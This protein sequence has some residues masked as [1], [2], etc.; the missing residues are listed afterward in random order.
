M[1]ALLALLACLVAGPESDLD[2]ITQRFDLTRVSEPATGRETLRGPGLTVTFAPGLRIA[3]VNGDVMTLEAPVEISGGKIRLPAS[4]ASLIERLA[5]ARKARPD[6]KPAKP[7][8]RA[9]QLDRPFKIVIDAG[10]GGIH[11]GCTARGGYTEKEVTLDV[12]RRLKELLES[13]GA[14]VVMTRTSD[15]HFSEDIDTDLMHRVRVSDRARPD[16]FL[17]IHC[18]WV[19]N[20]EVRGF[21]IFVSSYPK[22]DGGDSRRMA[23]DVRSMFR[24]GLDTEDRGIKEAGFKVV[25]HTDAPAVLVELDFISNP[26][27]SRQF[28]DPDHRQHVAGLLAEA[29]RRF[30]SR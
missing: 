8:A 27:S 23:A 16:L 1:I 19:A 20:P 13:M 2:R 18:N 26:V 30:A 7:A 6:P 11:T 21:E 24:S 5:Q 12:S 4:L 15:R 14:E 3:L 9:D 28:A 25:R 29:V 10:H 22:A 17:S